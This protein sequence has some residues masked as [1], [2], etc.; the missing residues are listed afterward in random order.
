MTDADSC[1]L[2]MNHAVT[3]VGWGTDD[4][5]GNY[6]IIKNSWNTSW[7]ESGYARIGLDDNVCGIRFDLN[8]A[9]SE[10]STTPTE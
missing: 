4:T 10:A 6:M 9:I 5:A 8:Y 1:R 2:A 3:A 7:G